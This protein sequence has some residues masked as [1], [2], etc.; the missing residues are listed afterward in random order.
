MST[1]GK[2]TAKDMRKFDDGAREL[3]LRM[4]D[5]GWVGRITKQ[6]HAYMRAP[7]GEVSA[8]VARDSGRGRSG[9]NAEARFRRWQEGRDNSNT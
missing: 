5:A 4:V 2:L 3:V 1:Y 9:M 6:G 7:D 8:T